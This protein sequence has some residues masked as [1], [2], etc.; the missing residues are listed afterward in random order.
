MLA[1][2]RRP[3]DFFRDVR[4]TAP[5]AL[6]NVHHPRLDA[7]I[8]YFDIGHFDAH[9]DK[10]G[11]AG[12]SYDFDAVEVMNGY[13]D[14]VRRSVDRV[15]DDWFSLLNHEHLVTATGNSDTHHLTFNIGGYPRNYVHLR[16]DR[17]KT[18]NVQLSPEAAPLY[19]AAAQQY[20]KLKTLLNRLDK[21]SKTILRHQAELA[22][23]KRKN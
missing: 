17:P 13:Q 23:S 19:R 3:D 5:D 11:R 9:S 6:I 15:I 8:G 14:P 7:E 20:R 1:H 10:A 16:D 18:V 21:L 12:F 2:G 22:A 4:K